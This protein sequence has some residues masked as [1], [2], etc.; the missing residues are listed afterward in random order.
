MFI[1]MKS[2][3]SARPKMVLTYWGCWQALWSDG[4]LC[5][6]NGRGDGLVVDV[7]F[8]RRDSFEEDLS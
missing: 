3:M 6:G 2:M 1:P 4:L 8:C 7:L 5:V